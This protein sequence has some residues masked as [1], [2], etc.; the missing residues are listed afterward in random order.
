L[1]AAQVGLDV[2]SH[3]VANANTVGFTRQRANFVTRTPYASPVGPIG[4]GSDVAD[5]ARTRDAFLDARVRSSSAVAGEFSVHA[6]LMG[7]VEGVLG[8]PENGASGELAELWASFEDLSLSPDDAATR[9]Q[10][11][12][13]LGSLTARLRSVADGWDRLAAD[14]ETR[15]EVTTEGINDVLAR[16]VTLN[17]AIPDTLAREGT[18]NDLHDERDLLLDQLSSQLGGAVTYESDGT[19]TVQLDGV[20]VVRG[21][22]AATLQVTPDHRLTDGTTVMNPGG[23][24]AGIRGF[25]ETDLPATRG[26]LDAFT[27]ALGEALNTQHA[28]GRTTAGAAGAPLVSGHGS[29]GTITVAISDPAALAAGLGPAPVARHDGRNAAALGDLRTTPQASGATLDEQLRDLA[30]TLGRDVASAQRAADAQ[31]GVAAAA[32]LARQNV[33][34]VSLDEEM[35]SLVQ[36]QRSLEAASRIMTAVDQALDVLINRT[37]LVGR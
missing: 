12:S 28:Q 32:T 24:L 27:F 25:L 33:H 3:N 16:I 1:R 10:V 21:L 29:A 34:G 17:R 14:T 7:R 8:E 2:A 13:T 4:T 30:T 5:I 22:T 31:E 18:P 19:V 20:D 9:R 6:E 36:F 35:V 23:E 15:M 11:L 26:Q 37:G